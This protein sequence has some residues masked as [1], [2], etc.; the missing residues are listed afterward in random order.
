MGEDVY[1]LVMQNDSNSGGYTQWFNFKVSNGKWKGTVTFNIVN[2]V[3][4]SIFS[5][6]RRLCTKRE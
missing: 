4:M 5:T 3:Y 1:D 2:F 6:K